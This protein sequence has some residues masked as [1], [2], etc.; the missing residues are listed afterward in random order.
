MLRRL[1]DV[2]GIPKEA[3]M[4]VFIRGSF[5]YRRRTRRNRECFYPAWPRNV[6]VLRY[7][8]INDAFN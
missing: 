5:R 2:K 6:A 4:E 1:N 3:Q 7:L 8:L